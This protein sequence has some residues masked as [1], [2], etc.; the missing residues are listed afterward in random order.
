MIDGHASVER[1]AALTS[2]VEL[3]REAAVAEVG[4]EMVGDHLGVVMEDER[5]ATH[6]FTCLN[7]AYLGWRWAVTEIGRAHV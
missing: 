4:A 5:L 7:P 2:A 1:D 3:A 6:T